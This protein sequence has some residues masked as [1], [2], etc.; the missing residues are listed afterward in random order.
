MGNSLVK[1]AVFALAISASGVHAL[2]INEIRID[3]PAADNDEYFE[4]VGDADKSL[5]GVSY[6]VIGDGQG[7]SGTLEALIPLDGLVMPEDGFFLATETTFSLNGDLPDLVT[8]LNF[9]NSDNVTHM[10]VSQ[11]SIDFAVGDDLDTDNDGMLDEMPWGSII[12]VVSLV[13][14][15]D[16][17]A[18]SS[19]HFYGDAL[20]Y[21]EIG[22]TEDG[23]GPSHIFRISDEGSSWAIGDFNPGEAD[24]PGLSNTGLII[25]PPMFDCDFN[26]DGACDIADIDSLTAVGNLVEGVT[27]GF[28]PI[29]DL[30]ADN[31]VDGDDLS[32][33][34]SSAGERNG[35]SEPL[36]RGDAN[37]DGVIDASD[38]NAVGLQ[39][40][41]NGS[42]WSQGDFDGDGIVGPSDLNA[43]GLGWLQ[44]VP[45]SPQPAAVPEPASRIMLTWIA[46]GWALRRCSR[47]RRSS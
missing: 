38:L 33:W 43:V 25:E 8:T 36:Q 34:L 4:L 22:P 10:L 2:E 15:A 31:R 11:F 17:S 42:V 18:P 16:L 39:W 3:Q 28:N 1:C 23:F 27:Q 24:T 26:A 46:L 45:K 7:G 5:D 44:S 37:L 6:V 35:F 12:D 40:L 19:E 14:S 32:Q 47:V 21:A 30:T 13:E 29:F 20:G 9:E 41:Q